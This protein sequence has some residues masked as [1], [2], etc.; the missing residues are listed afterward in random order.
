MKKDAHVVLPVVAG[1]PLGRAYGH[2]LPRNILA[3]QIGKCVNDERCGE[4]PCPCG[5]WQ[6]A[7][8]NP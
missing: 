3:D 1:S 6:P 5:F 7:P 4:M 2:T 8:A